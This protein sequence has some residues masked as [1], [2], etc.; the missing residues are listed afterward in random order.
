[1]PKE[2]IR[3]MV[4]RAYE[5]YRLGHREFVVDMLDDEIDWTFHGPAELLPTPHHV[6]G[7]AAVL[8]A[9]KMFD[10]TTETIEQKLN[11]VLVDGEHAAA[12]GERKFRHRSSG[13]I[14]H[15]KFAAFQLYRNGRLIEYQMFLDTFSMAQQLMGRAI[16]VPALYP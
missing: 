9:Y 8:A 14:V 3:E 6:H 12:L 16:D 10:D 5:A 13:R 1:M 15:Y 2:I 11:L 4:Y 7:K